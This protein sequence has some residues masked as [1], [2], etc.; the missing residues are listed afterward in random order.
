MRKT[1]RLRCIIIVAVFALT[2]FAGVFA[3]FYSADA[4]AMSALSHGSGTESD[5]YVISTMNQLSNLQAISSSDLSYEYTKDK[6]FRLDRD[7]TTSYTIVTTSNGFYGHLDGNGHTVRILSETGLFNR[8]L[9]GASISNLTV[10][11]N[12][13]VDYVDDYFG[14]VY[15][16]DEGATVDNCTIYGNVTIDH[17]KWKNRFQTMGQYLE[18]GL[19]ANTNNGVISNCHVYGSVIQPNLELF[20]SGS[21]IRICLYAPF[22]SGKIVNCDI[23]AD[24]EL[25]VSST[26]YYFSGFSIEN[27]VQNCAFTGDILV[28]STGSTLTGM[29]LYVYALGQKAENSVYTGNIVFDHKN[30]AFHRQAKHVVAVSGIEGSCVHNGTIEIINQSTKAN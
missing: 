29:K 6:Y 23:F 22:G 8:L 19:I 17:S 20:C 18:C 13:E 4:F 14:L 1:I 24:V 3:I 2:A 5:P 7:L 27:S 10:K 28:N 25:A 30:A 21:D 9:G 12:L 16:I 26:G 15:V 11:V